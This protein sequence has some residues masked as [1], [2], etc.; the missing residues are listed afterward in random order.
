MKYFN[1]NLDD[2]LNSFLN[3][4]YSATPIIMTSTSSMSPKQTEEDYELNITKDGAYLLFE[5]PGF[6]KTNLSVYLESGTLFIDGKR[7][8]KLNGEEVNKTLNKKISISEEYSPETIEAT[9][10]DG[11]LTVFIPNY[12]KK[13]KKR[14]NII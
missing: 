8:Y 14:I 5:V 4:R 12:K 1:S 2:F 7:T 10:D 3:S 11:I 13:E 9:I 6:N